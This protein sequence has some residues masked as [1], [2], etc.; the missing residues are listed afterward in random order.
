MASNEFQQTAQDDDR[1]VFVVH[2][3]NLAARDAMFSFLRSIDLKPIEWTEA[4]S[5]AIADEAGLSPYIGDVLEVAFGKAKAI[6]VLMTPD[7]IAYLR[8]DIDDIALQ[9]EDPECQPSEQ[10][11][12]NVLFEAGMAMGINPNGT[13]LIKLGS[14]RPFSDIVG[15]HTIVIKD[16]PEWRHDLVKR[17]ESAG[18]PVD[19]DGTDWLRSG[20]FSIPPSIESE[21]VADIMSHV[22]V[23]GPQKMVDIQYRSEGSGGII[24]IR[25]CSTF[26][27]KVVDLQ[28]PSEVEGLQI[29]GPGLPEEELPPG[30]AIKLHTVH[31]ALPCPDHFNL[32]VVYIDHESVEVREPVFIS[33]VD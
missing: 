9:G 4:I 13:I 8:N 11:R 23:Q 20:N 7:E 21:D 19:N 29:V 30:K 31:E 27:I 26:P 5:S 18:C 24:E 28:F 12:P 15:R 2:G 1:R 14:T 3:R 25:N 16:G 10:V 32:D 6:V 17:L 22:G 33:L